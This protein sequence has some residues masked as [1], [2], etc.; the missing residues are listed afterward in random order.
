MYV[1]EYLNEVPSPSLV[2]DCP[3]CPG[4]RYLTPRD[5]AIALMYKL[6]EFQERNARGT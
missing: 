5:L 1:P 4:Y 6:R 3:A 2:P